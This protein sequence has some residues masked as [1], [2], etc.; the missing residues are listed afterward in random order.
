M[1]LTLLEGSYAVARSGPA[2]PV[3]SGILEGPGFRT[4]ARTE[5]ELSVIAP[6]SEIGDMDKV[7][8]GWVCFKVNGPFDFDEVGVTATLSRPLAEAGVALLMIAT[9]DTDYV[10]VKKDNALAAEAAWGRQGHTIAR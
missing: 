5:D 4:V 3:P 9:Y 6:E 2:S 7:D 10:L 1:R 8:G